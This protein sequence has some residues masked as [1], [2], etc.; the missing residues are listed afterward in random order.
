MDIH[1]RQKDIVDN[2]KRAFKSKTL[3]ELSAIT[4]I[5]M[6]RLHR[7]LSSNRP[8]RKFYKMYLWEAGVMR[9]ATLEQNFQSTKAQYEWR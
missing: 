1:D 2:F 7:L 8:N 4:G 9:R 3:K 6:T 5:Q